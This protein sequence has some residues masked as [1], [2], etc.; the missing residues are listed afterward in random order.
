MSGTTT[1]VKSN[2]WTYWYCFT[3]PSKRSTVKQR[4]VLLGVD[5]EPKMV[6]T[7]NLMMDIRKELI[8]F[9]QAGKAMGL[10]IRPA[11]DP[12]AVVDR[13]IEEIKTVYDGGP[14]LNKPPNF[15]PPKGGTYNYK[16]VT[17]VGVFR[18]RKSACKELTQVYGYE[19]SDSQIRR[20]CMYPDKII[21]VRSKKKCKGLFDGYLTYNDA[22]F[23]RVKT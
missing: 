16:Y 20:W 15:T 7:C 18:G 11:K 9:E 2:D 17:P 21:D 6:G 3:N 13:A 19:I 4:K 5:Y 22:G 12:Q 8:K 1:I 23:Y 10:T 14:L